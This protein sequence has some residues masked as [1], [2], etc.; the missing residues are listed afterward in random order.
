MTAVTAD[1][2]APAPLPPTELTRRAWRRHIGAALLLT[3][4]L[5]LPIYLTGH[6]YGYDWTTHLWM[7]WV[8]GHNVAGGGPSLFLHFD[9]LGVFFPY[10]AFYGGS[11]Y[12]IRS[13]P[14]RCCGRSRSSGRTWACCG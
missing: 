5:L 3:V 14:T 11:W 1:D 4:I 7:V 12:T 2:T 9:R 6:T 13:S 8:Q 10:Y